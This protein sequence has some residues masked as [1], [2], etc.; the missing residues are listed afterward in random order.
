MKLLHV[1][2]IVIC[3]DVFAQKTANTI[4]RSSINPCIVNEYKTTTIFTQTEIINTEFGINN[5]KIGSLFIINKSPYQVI[6]E[7]Y[8]YSLFKESSIHV[9]HA[10]NLNNHS[11]IGINI[12]Q[13]VIQIEQKKTMLP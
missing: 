9:S 3:V 13:H 7:Q 12:N 1:I 2:A 11:V 5:N 10:K 4:L 6:Y 8:G